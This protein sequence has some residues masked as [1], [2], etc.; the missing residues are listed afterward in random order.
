VRVSVED[1]G[2]GIPREDLA[3]LFQGFTQLAAQP[4]KRAGGTGLGLAIARR[5][6]E[7]HGGHLGGESRAGSGSTFFFTLPLPGSRSLDRLPALP[8]ALRR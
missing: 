8:G 2:I 4:G 5:I 6:V 3:R 1:Q 7:L